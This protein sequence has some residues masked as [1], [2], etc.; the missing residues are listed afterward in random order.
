LVEQEVLCFAAFAICGI[1][2][3]MDSTVL[4]ID[5]AINRKIVQWL[6]LFDQ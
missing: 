5:A 3:T 2:I 6:L 1:G 4:M